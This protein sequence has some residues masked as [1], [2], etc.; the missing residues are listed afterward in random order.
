MARP[1]DSVHDQRMRTV[2]ALVLLAACNASSTDVGSAPASTAPSG[3][4]TASQPPMDSGAKDAGPHGASAALQQCAKSKG[5]IGSIAAA[6]A[7]LNALGPN[8]DVPCFIATLPRPLAVVATSGT[9]SAQPAVGMS[10]PRILLMLPKLVITVVPAGEGSKLL[11]FG[12]WLGSTRT[13]KW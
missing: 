13:I 11:E 8:T 4:P 6:V 5:E 1:A 3:S 7:R 12:E 10:A 2:L 9:S